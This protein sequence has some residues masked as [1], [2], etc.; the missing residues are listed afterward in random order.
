MRPPI[1]T[2]HTPP[3]Q[4]RPRC[5]ITFI[6]P[7]KP[8]TERFRELAL[9][10][11][12]ASRHYR[13]EVHTNLVCDLLELTNLGLACSVRGVPADRL[14]PWSLHK[15]HTHLRV[16]SPPESEYAQLEQPESPYIHIDSD[17]F[18]IDPLPEK[19]L[20]AR[21]FA[22]NPEATKLYADMLRSNAAWLTEFAQTSP[23]HAYN[24]GIIGGNPADVLEYARLAAKSACFPN[25]M[26]TWV[27][28]AVLGRFHDRI[29]TLLNDGE[30]RPMS[31]GSK[32][33][34]LMDAKGDI[35]MQGRIARRLA[36]ECPE[37]AKFLGCGA[38]G[39]H[40]SK[41]VTAGDVRDFYHRRTPKRRPLPH[42]SPIDCSK[43]TLTVA[44]S[45]LGDV[46]MLT[47]LEAA[48]RRVGKVAHTRSESP[49]YY[50]VMQFCPA[51]T[52]TPTPYQACLVQGL[53]Q[54][55]LGGGHNFQR[56]NRW[57]GFPIDAVPKGDLVVPN[58]GRISGRVSIHTAPSKYARGWQ[59]THLHPRARVLYPDTLSAI[60]EVARCRRFTFIEVGSQRTLRHPRIEDGTGDSIERMIRLMAECEYHIG[61]LSGPTH[62]AAALGLK[63]VTIINFPHPA[64][65][66]LPN[67]IDGGV[68]EEEWLYPQSAVLHQDDDSRHWPKITGAK[69]I[70]AA[71]DGHV[72]PYWDNTILEEL[73]QWQ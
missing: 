70:M 67:M 50:P 33:V 31:E 45:G 66:M 25:L 59:S 32:Y 11:Y 48:A 61:V 9:A 6:W 43:F 53:L 52:D 29:E 39:I 20:S 35:V 69:S 13:V 30:V 68:V 63:I 60:M 14:S 41:K 57:F 71:L 27:E 1:H 10:I 44:P 22:Q 4:L 56:A 15:I 18:L 26:P 37:V 8:G 5:H 12:F 58:V 42:W 21:L 23:F 19:L 54:H 2:G 51:H 16:L 17:V 34:H 38:A 7:N 49:H 46:M 73:A 36:R 62:V 64:T 28:Q 47:G 65:L 55:G 24:C 40:H 3:S 72:Y